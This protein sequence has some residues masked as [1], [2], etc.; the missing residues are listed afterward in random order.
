M[1][2]HLLLQ[3]NVLLL[4]EI[5]ELRRELKKA[6]SQLHDLNV[7][8]KMEGKAKG[9]QGVKDGALKRAAVTATMAPQKHNQRPESPR[10][11]DDQLQHTIEQQRLE[12]RRLRLE[13]RDLKQGL[14][15]SP[16]GRLP[17]L[18]TSSQPVQVE[19]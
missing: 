13:L 9:R 18:T 7:K 2:L 4:Q 8:V 15:S 19:Q 12:M 1:F 6:R 16:A 14:P 17:P 11:S 3:E 10:P 5:S